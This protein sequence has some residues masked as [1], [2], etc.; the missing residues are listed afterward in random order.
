VL[1]GVF[2]TWPQAGRMSTHVASHGD[3]YFSLWRLEWIARALSTDPRTLFDANIFYPARNTLAYSDAMLL[4]GVLGTPLLWS[5]VSSVL[6]YNLLLM[7]G[8]V[9]SGIGMYVL[10][11]HL[12]HST[13]AAIVAAAVFTMAPYRIEHFMHLELQWTMWMPLTFWAVHR[14]IESPSRRAGAVAGVFLWL[15]IVSCVYY[16]VFLALV[17]AALVALLLIAQPR[18]TWRALPI[19]VFGGVIAALLTA[20]YLW[21]Y[22]KAMRTFGGRDPV[23]VARYS[24]HAV[25]YLASPEQNWLWGWTM[26]RWGDVEL[27]LFPGLTACALGAI[28]LTARPRRHVIVYA[29]LAAL[30][31][32]LSFGAHGWLYPFLAQFVPGL[33]GLRSPAR[34]GI[35]AGA[36][37]A[38]LAGFGMRVLEERSRPSRRVGGLFAAALIMMAVEYANTGMRLMPLTDPSQ[39]PL[40]RVVRMAR[41]GVVAELPMPSPST[42]PGR[43]A[44][45]VFWSSAHWKPLVNGYSGYFPPE[46]IRTLQRMTNFPDDQSIAALRSLDVR[47]LVVQRAYYDPASYTAL[48]LRA[49]TRPELRPY[50]KYRGPA[51]EAEL[52]LLEPQ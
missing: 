26:E 6:T 31:I 7:G 48:M 45:Y 52:F 19:L 43:E 42:L 13:T 3:A 20:P 44:D 12:T 50:G 30:S 15:Q 14:A 11:R 24:A 18:R 8:I 4:E 16:G 39:T 49:A 21:P 46:Y 29:L 38:V 23:E 2:V 1:F 34:F 10:V 5:G 36:T 25:S 47:Y 28:A 22:V 27:N 35:L 17:T 51:G 40:Y 41:P 37:I 9:G 32:A 33:N